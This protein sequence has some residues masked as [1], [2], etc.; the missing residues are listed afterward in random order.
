MKRSVLFL[1]VFMFLLGNGL[2]YAEDTDRPGYPFDDEVFALLPEFPDDFFEIKIL[3][4]RGSIGASHLS[5]EYLQPELIPNWEYWS[6]RIYADEDYS[7]FGKYG[8]S[9]YPSFINYKNVEK[10][11]V[12]NFSVLF[13]ADWGIKFYQGCSIVIPDVEG[14]SIELEHP[15]HYD[16]L[17]CPTF[18]QFVPGWLSSASFRITVLET[19]DYHFNIHDG[20][21]SR[22]SSDAWG[23]MYGERYTDVGSLTYAPIIIDIQQPVYEQEADGMPFVIT[24]TISFIIVA[25]IVLLLIYHVQRKLDEKSKK[26]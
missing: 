9:F 19:G 25:C 13:R 7:Q 3:F 21:P 12:I 14:L 16:V 4:D 22:L 20:K 5:D 26:G 10:G 24:M 23:L 8:I 1:A 6:N 2:V 11:N 15:G 17:L 18:P